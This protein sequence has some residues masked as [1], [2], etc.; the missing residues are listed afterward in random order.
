MGFA[1]DVLE[2]GPLFRTVWAFGGVDASN[3]CSPVGSLGVLN[4]V[5]SA[6]GSDSS[7]TITQV[8]AYSC[9]GYISVPATSD[10]RGAHTV[11]HPV[12]A[13]PARWRTGIWG[14]S[15]TSSG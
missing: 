10:K 5:E 15:V 7:C 6:Y 13:D 14:Q 3:Y 11:S 1:K 4:K 2:N 8:N 9:K 12:T